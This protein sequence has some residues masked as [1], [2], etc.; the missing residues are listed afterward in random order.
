MIQD[1]TPDEILRESQLEM[2]LFSQADKI[3]ELLRMLEKVEEDGKNLNDFEQLQV[4]NSFSPT[5]GRKLMPCMM[6]DL[7]QTSI[8]LRPKIV[9]LI[10]KYSIKKSRS[11]LF[12]SLLPSTDA[13][14]SLQPN[15]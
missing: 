6:Q 8:T 10:E 1:P 7:Y 3:E 13:I 2:Q 14:L 4:G 9:K 12:P 11:I 5:R 15:W